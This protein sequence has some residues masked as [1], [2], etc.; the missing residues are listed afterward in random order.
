MQMLLTC[1]FCLAGYVCAANLRAHPK[2]GSV[3]LPANV[4]TEVRAV[5]I[6][7]PDAATVSML[8]SGRFAR[9]TPQT[10][11]PDLFV[12]V[13]TTRVTP[14]EKRNAIRALWREVDG[15][16][17]NICARFVVC[18]RVDPYQQAL[19]AE[20][21][22]NGDLLFLPCEEGYAQGL[23]TKK[24]VATMKAY[25]EASKNND[26]CMNRA[27]FMK[28]DDDT[29]VG[30][31]RFRQGL[32]AA[33]SMYGELIYAGVD[34]PAQPPDRNPASQWY[35]P[36]AAWPQPN[37]PPAMYGGPG[38]ILGRSMIQRIVD[39]GIADQYILWNEDRAVGV[40]VNALQQRGVFINWVRIPG[41][42]GFFWDKPVKSGPWGQYPY[43]LAH[44]LSQACILCL[45][46]VDRTN[47]PTVMTDACFALDPL[48]EPA[49]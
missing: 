24:V 18:N 7:S 27:L 8:F 34:L 14:I 3:A 22:S 47:N 12:A 40:W 21:H 11:P 20:A 32:T 43:V 33:S 2:T 23:L 46:N 9:Q 48:P 4:S 15:G 42:N 36:M 13:F 29:F 6:T 31:Y 26:V 30:G 16:P 39:E 25:R 28:V 19:Q 1:L 35:E 17:G 49:R 10:P 38:Y 37:Y 45:V 41:T 44:H 5:N